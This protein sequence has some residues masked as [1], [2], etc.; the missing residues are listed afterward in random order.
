MDFVK[1]PFIQAPSI[2]MR[3]GSHRDNGVFLA[4]GDAF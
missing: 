2:A 3:M 1:E 4:K